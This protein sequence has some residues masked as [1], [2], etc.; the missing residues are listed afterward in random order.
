MQD[1]ILNNKK[2]LSLS[3][4]LLIN[5]NHNPNQERISLLLIQREISYLDRKKEILQ[6]IYQWLFKFINKILHQL[7]A[8]IHL[9]KRDFLKE[10][11]LM[12][13]LK[14]T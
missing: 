3:K 4:L 14:I 7:P 13:H 5:N 8:K 2:L 9:F 1:K 10:V 12:E 11:L 6:M